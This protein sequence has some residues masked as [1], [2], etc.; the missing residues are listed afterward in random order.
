[1]RYCRKKLVRQKGVCMP[2]ETHK[3]NNH[4]FE[5]VA[6][7]KHKLS[8]VLKH[9]ERKIPEGKERACAITKLEECAFWGTRGIAMKPECHEDAAKTY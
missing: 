5:E 7:F 2:L 3:L 8:E 4:G 1:M 9:I 6:Q